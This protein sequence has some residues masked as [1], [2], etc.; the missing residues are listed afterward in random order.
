VKNIFGAV[1]G[2]MVV[3]RL[4][5][6]QVTQPLVAVH[7]SELTRALETMP[8]TGSTPTGPGTTGFQWWPTDWHYFVM[9]E[10]VKEALRSDGTAFTVVGD[11]DISANSLLNGGAP[12]YPIM[13]S[14]A[15]EA[16]RDDEIAPLTNYVAAGGFLFVGSS[17]FT[18][19]PDGSTRGNFALANQ[20]GVRVVTSGL[21]NWA[22]NNFFTKQIDHRLISHV[23]SGQNTWRMPAY[24]EE[25][26]WG[27]SPS[28]PFLASHDIWQVQ[29]NGA[30]T[31]AVGDN[32]PFLLMKPYGKGYFIYCSA[33]QPLI[34]HG[35]FAP[36]MYSYVILRRAIEWAFESANLAVPKVSPWPYQYDAAFMIRHD[37]ENYTNEIADILLSAKV[38]TTNGAKGDYYF[39]TGTLREDAASKYNTNT[40]VTNMRL[41][42]SSYGA[43]VGPHN[44]GLKNPNNPSLVRGNYDYWHWGP[45]EA[46]DV[47]PS[48]YSSGKA[49]AQA[50]LQ[51]SFTDIERW[52]TGLNP[53][54]RAWVGCYFNSTRDDSYDLQ[55]QVNVKIAGDQKIGPF[56][57][58]TFS[59]ATPGKRYPFVT[60]PVSDW[61]VGG[62]VAQSLEPWHPPGV[63][64]SQTMHD[65][66][67]FYYNLGALI[68]IYSHTLSTGEGDAGQLVPD[69][70]TY[71]LNTNLHPRIWS[72]NALSVYQ[73]W[74]QR[75]NAQVSASCT[76]NGS[77][78]TITLAI[79]GS[80]SPNT[81]VELLLPGTNSFCGFQLTTNGVLAGPSAFRVNGQVV[82]I[83]VGTS[84]ST[85]TFSYWPVGSLAGVFSENFDSISS[86][87]LPSGWT[88]T[89]SGAQTPWVTQTSLRDTS[90]NAAA[91]GDASNVG[92]NELISPSIALPAGNAQ[93]TFRNNYD[94]ETGPGTDGYDGG[95]L[96]IKIG[97]GNFTDIVSAGGSFVTG[98]YNSI[99]DTGYANPL[100]GRAAWSGTSGGF[101]TTSVNLPLTASGQNIQLKWRCGTDNGNALT[102]W[103]IDSISISNR[104]C[105]CCGGNSTNTAPVL[106]TQ[107][108]RTIPELSTLTVN[109]AATDS[110]SP[111]NILTYTLI[112][113]P[114]GASISS[115]GII[116]WTPTEAQGPSAN[117]FTTRVT[118]NGSPP[119]SATNS[120]QVLVSEVNR[121]PVLPVQNSRTVTTGTT[122]TVTNTASDS[123]IPVNALAYS[124]VN[125]PSG[126][127]IDSNGII[128]WTPTTAQGPSTNSITTVVTDDGSPPLSATNSFTVVVTSINNPP[129]LT[130]QPTS[131]TNVAGTTATFTVGATG[132]SLTYQWLKSSLP[133]SGATSSILTLSSVTSAD[134]AGYSVTVANSFGSVTSLTATLT[135]I[136]P[137]AIVT[138]PASQTN[139]AGT[140]ATFTVVASGTA[141]SYRWV[142]N[143]TNTLNGGNISGATTPSLTLSNLTSSDAASYTVVLTNLAGSVTSSPA[144]LTV[145]VTNAPGPLF[146]DDF[147]HSGLAPWIAQSGVWKVNNGVMKGGN[148]PLQSYAA[149]YITNSWAD[150]SVQAQFQ[151]QSKAYGGGLG[152]RLNPATGAH[153]GAW[154]FPENSTG[155]AK[156]LK[157]LKF[158]GWN[159]WAYNGVANAPMA[160]VNLASV[161]TGFH[162]LTMS[163]SGPLI[164]VVFDNTQLISMTDT[165]ANPY[166][167]GAVCLDMWT[168][169]TSYTMTVDN[170]VVNSLTS[171]AP[172]PAVTEIPPV[173]VPP[174][175]QGIAINAGAASIT[176]Q[177]VPG[178]TYRLQYSAS[179]SGGDWTDISPDI[180]ATAET[181]TISQ[182]LGDEPQRFFRVLLLP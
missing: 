9:P 21:V 2:L 89:A 49:Y 19:N 166:L 108:D 70:I 32:Y 110:D 99:I 151:F 10:A 116:T 65:A 66:V 55:A 114:A 162:T 16:L 139:N 165:E 175:I 38:E 157:L 136:V 31:L 124:L 96:E 85:A 90:P 134:A 131:R 47:T 138:Q 122:I 173:I 113:A 106:P 133:I 30:T 69:Y 111:P 13:I 77:Q 57:H 164:T 20:M 143:G 28:H 56:P 141:P 142:K 149:T 74:L 4:A 25:I 94:L 163:F 119:L 155:G 177:T 117:T 36:G 75:S 130:S 145:I 125:P 100:A 26:S 86:P 168:A 79:A 83:L 93:L 24:S 42:V 68:N 39:C 37:L 48:G 8:A 156:T 160:Q 137:P 159:S 51:A 35:G 146:S 128:T 153:Y 27:T 14:L 50:S 176:W 46:L 76:Q 87:G 167:S 174:I 45:D 73:W 148:D 154:I 170:L 95:V 11:S 109:N 104:G 180:I 1:F 88:T 121:A 23:P 171:G 152:G 80:A 33:F 64:T 107:I 181:A 115:S 5:S 182:P 144:T 169:S 140:A 150:Y 17:A 135:V 178:M 62:L 63:H 34:G 97:N 43:T 15:S 58:W 78:T 112:A 54:T 161:R 41:A 22:Q 118:D 84:V 172:A 102:G 123:D 147:S 103:R 6:A 132:A 40:I 12:R 18:R 59:T 53:G 7:D 3:A 29:A 120:F 60:E 105:L 92:L 126:A 98:G 101:I 61:F 129:V 72:A 82:K 127:A 67:D 81:T 91:S 52:L 179:P 158:Q 44:G 71:S